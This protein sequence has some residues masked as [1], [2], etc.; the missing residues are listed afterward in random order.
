VTE[1]LQ[2][3]SRLEQA[4]GKLALDGDRIRYSIPIGDTEVKTLLAQLREHREGVKE[5]LRQRAD[6][7][8]NF[9][10]NFVG[11]E[12]RFGYAHARFFP[13]IGRKVRTP[14]GLGTL[15]QVFAGR[16]TVLLDSQLRQ[17]SFFLPSDIE[18]LSWEP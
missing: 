3:V 12:S 16:V 4:G 18:P 1:V 8:Q 17:C 9:S 11:P 10:G 6:A 14:A 13:F 5:F 2:I 7:E 15:V